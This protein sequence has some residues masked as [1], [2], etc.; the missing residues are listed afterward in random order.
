MPLQDVIFMSFQL[1][2]KDFIVHNDVIDVGSV[3]D[4]YELV[5]RGVSNNNSKE[6]VVLI[7]ECFRQITVRLKYGR[8]VSGT[9]CVG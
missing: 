8:E 9:M 3:Q 2:Y 6:Q 5:A 1:T 4:H 7:Q